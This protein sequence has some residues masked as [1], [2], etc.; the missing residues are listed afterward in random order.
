M[1]R[2]VVIMN[3]GNHRPIHTYY[4]VTRYNRYL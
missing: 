4:L 1:I 3:K 2:V